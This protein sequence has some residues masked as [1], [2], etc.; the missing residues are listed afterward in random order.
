VSEEHALAT[1]L[2]AVDP[3]PVG[4]RVVPDEDVRM[5]PGDVWWGGSPSR[6]VRLTPAGSRLWQQLRTGPVTSRAAGVLARR[7]TD[8]GLA[9]PRPPRPETAPDVT[10]VIPVR[11]RAAMLARCLDALGD[12]HPV[13]VVD[14]GSA[15]SA[16]I[17]AVAD[18]PGVTLLR[19]DRNRGPAA[20]RNTA[21]RRVRTELVA[22]LDSDCVPADGWIDSLAAHFADPVVAAVA[23]RIVALAGGGHRACGLD[24]GD[25]PARV[26]PQTAVSFVPTAALLVRRPAVLDIGRAG[27]VFDPELRVGEDVDLVW[28]L[29]EAG[30][31]VRYDPEVRVAHEEPA[32]LPRVLARRFRYG[33]SA[34]PLALRHPESVAPLI[35]HP[36]AALTV[37]ALL[38]RRPLVAF[39]GMVGCLA[40][41]SVPLDRA[42]VPADLAVGAAAAGVRRTGIEMGRYATQF[43]TPALLAAAL[44]GG[45]RKWWRRLAIAALLLVPGLRAPGL[46]RRPVR[47]MAGQIADDIAYGSGVWAG[48]LRYRTWIPLRPKIIRPHIQKNN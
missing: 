2:T 30:W 3:L 21:L 4:F 22:L 46:R 33:T 23:P 42:G 1:A 25:R 9:H 6:V 37:L 11:D 35:L 10:V 40:T 32:A 48:C 31:R 13:V 7:L 38:A 24:L 29:D 16:A 43:A 36:W 14:D 20:A 5:L 19:H 12:A 27:A 8:A 47:A 15:G 41:M 18:R 44:P 39:G 28:R 34:A 26:R 17:A 45:R